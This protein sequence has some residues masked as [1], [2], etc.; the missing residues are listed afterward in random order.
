MLVVVPIYYLNNVELIYSTLLQI[1]NTVKDTR[2]LI[3]DNTPD[4]T[5]YNKLKEISD[6]Y[7]EAKE[8]MGLGFAYNLGL[9]LAKLTNEKW[10]LILDQ[11]SRI[12]DIYELRI[13]IE[14]LYSMNLDNNVAIISINKRYGYCR[15]SLINNDFYECK[16]VINSGSLLNVNICWRYRYDEKLLVDRIDNEYCYKL[17]KNGYHIL[18]YKKQILAHDIGR[19]TLQFKKNL[20]RII[21]FII[22]SFAIFHGLGVF[23]NSH[24]IR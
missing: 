18:A 20:S 9:S 21:L 8:N 16:S 6:W 7:L 5:P 1:K 14:K 13:F 11:D 3:I 2:I 19:G 17:R 4:H 22:K 15:N 23:S 12:I 10:L 24:E